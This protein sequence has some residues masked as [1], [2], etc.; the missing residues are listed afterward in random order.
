MG[1]LQPGPTAKPISKTHRLKIQALQL[2]SR[3]VPIMGEY[4]VSSPP[5]QLPPHGFFPSNIRN[6]RPRSK[7]QQ[8]EGTAIGIGRKNTTQTHPGVWHED[9]TFQRPSGMSLKKDWWVIT[10]SNRGPAD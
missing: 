3:Q 7:P 9:R 10:G 4:D 2:S 1:Q 6:G 5:P 8:T